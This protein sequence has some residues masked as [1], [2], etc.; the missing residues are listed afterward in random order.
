M[1]LGNGR[2]SLQR[3]ETQVKP[4]EVSRACLAESIRAIDS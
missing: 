2:R 4:E 1:K 3:E